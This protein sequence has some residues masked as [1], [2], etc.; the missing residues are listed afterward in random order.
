MQRRWKWL[1]VVAILALLAVPTASRLLQ[2]P[3]VTDSRYQRIHVGQS[4][5][6]VEAIIGGPPGSYG[7]GPLSEYR[8]ETIMWR[9]PDKSAAD[10]PEIK[11]EGL[12][13]QPAAHFGTEVSLIDGFAPSRCWG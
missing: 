1:G 3:R 4:L 2:Y 10:L 5:A 11:L 12:Q 6:E 7:G 9:A 8:P 13:A